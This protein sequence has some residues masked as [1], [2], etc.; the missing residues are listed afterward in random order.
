M[1]HVDRIKV[2]SSGALLLKDF[3]EKKCYT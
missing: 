1:K 2:D 3:D